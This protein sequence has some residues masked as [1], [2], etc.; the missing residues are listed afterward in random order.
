MPSVIHTIHE[1]LGHP[2]HTLTTRN[3][4]NIYYNRLARKMI[5]NY[6]SSCI[7]C[8][9]A[10]KYDVKK[11]QSSTAR[12]MQPTRPRQCLYADLIPM[13]KGQFSYILFCLDAYSQYVYAIPL[14]DKTSPSILQGFL[15]LF[16]SS[17]FYEQ[18]YLDNETSFQS[19]ANCSSAPATETE[20]INT[21]NVHLETSQ[22]Y[23]RTLNTSKKEQVSFKL[24][25]NM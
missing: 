14:K 1:E 5:R 23:R 8:S 21:L 18:I 9:F 7:T 16:A 3:F 10:T 4:Q 15:S 6:V 25:K 24:T 2:S 12:T 20:K 13:I 11:V 19:A 22:K 17:G